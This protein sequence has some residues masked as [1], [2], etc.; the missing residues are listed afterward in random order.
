M[1]PGKTK[2]E[3]AKICD[4]DMLFVVGENETQMP[5]SRE[6]AKQTMMCPC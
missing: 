5:I 6:M 2:L 1:G 4:R 3:K